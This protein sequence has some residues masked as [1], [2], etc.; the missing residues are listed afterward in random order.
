VVATTDPAV[1]ATGTHPGW[2][3]VAGCGVL[4]VVL[5]LLTTTSWALDTATATA[6]R[7][8]ADDPDA[9]QPGPLDAE[10]PVAARVG[11]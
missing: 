5:G 4:V 9:Q 2:W 6:A 11:V 1:L 7:L 10:R 3:L 8:C